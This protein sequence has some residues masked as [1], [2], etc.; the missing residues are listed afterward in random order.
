MAELSLRGLDKRAVLA[1]LYNA[2]SPGGAQ[3]LGWLA[4]QPGGMT[5]DEAASWLEGQQDFD[6]LQGRCLK[7]DLSGET[8]DPWRYDRDYGQGAA[9]RVL[10]HLIFERRGQAEAEAVQLL[11]QLPLPPPAGETIT[12]DLGALRPVWNGLLDLIAEFSAD[13]PLWR[14]IDQ[15]RDLQAHP[16]WVR[17]IFEGGP[18]PFLSDAWSRMERIDHLTGVEHSSASNTLTS[19]G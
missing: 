2:A 7:V 5:L 14:F 8:L 10:A 9:E 16:S 15:S 18:P 3:S 17:R 11:M 4:H 13:H 1:A 6:Y 12:H 19:P